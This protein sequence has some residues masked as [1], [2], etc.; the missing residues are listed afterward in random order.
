MPPAPFTPSMQDSVPLFLQETLV[1]TDLEPLVYKEWS[2]VV[3]TD[4]LKN[5]T[6]STMPRIALGDAL[7]KSLLRW[8]ELVAPELLVP[9]VLAV[10]DMGALT[11]TTF[12]PGLNAMH[13]YLC[14]DV[15]ATE[16]SVLSYAQLTV[17][18]FR[19]PAPQC[20]GTSQD[21]NG[22]TLLQ[23]LGSHIRFS[24]EH[25]FDVSES[26]DLQS[27]FAFLHHKSDSASHSLLSLRLARLHEGL[28]SLIAEV[29][30]T[31]YILR[32]VMIKRVSSKMLSLEHETS[33][34]VT[35]KDE[36]FKIR[37]FMIKRQKK[38]SSVRVLPVTSTFAITRVKYFIRGVRS[39]KALEKWSKWRHLW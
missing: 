34:N 30:S 1:H 22:P 27:A 24:L 4:N 21:L 10:D 12:V 9:R 17:R 39:Q 29:F 36:E 25:W 7:P 31:N 16:H 35:C 28:Q 11:V 26:T 32:N 14:L 37:V 13:A 6:N 15:L 5:A 19:I 8:V 20:F 38:K 2:G 18:M 3:A 33:W 23:V